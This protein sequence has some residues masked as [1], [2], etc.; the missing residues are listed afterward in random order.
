MGAL[1]FSSIA[2]NSGNDQPLLALARSPFCDIALAV[3]SPTTQHVPSA[4]GKQSTY[5]QG[6]VISFWASDNCA[7]G[8]PSTGTDVELELVEAG[9]AELD[10]APSLTFIRNTA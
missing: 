4:Y 9:V 8:V 6:V 5:Q 2:Q 10:T 1:L 3:F 7:H